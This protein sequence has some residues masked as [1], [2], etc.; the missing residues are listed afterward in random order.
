MDKEECI[1]NPRSSVVTSDTD[2]R[3]FTQMKSVFVDIVIRRLPKHEA[4]K[5][6][7]K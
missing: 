3:R 6:K 7:E 1:R 5:R 4:Q 2:Q